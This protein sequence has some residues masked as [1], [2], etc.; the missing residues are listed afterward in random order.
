MPDGVYD[1]ELSRFASLLDA[2]RAGGLDSTAQELESSSPLKQVVSGN[3]T[4]N[5]FQ[6]SWDRL[7]LDKWIAAEVQ[8][9][10]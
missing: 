7:R 1:S 4:G 9:A 8:L 2:L 5:H 10:T 3:S 6:G